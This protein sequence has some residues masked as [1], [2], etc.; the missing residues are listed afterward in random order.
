MSLALSET[1][2]ICFFALRRILCSYL[3]IKRQILLH[4]LD[5]TQIKGPGPKMIKVRK[6]LKL[7]LYYC[8]SFSIL[9]NIPVG[10]LLNIRMLDN[11]S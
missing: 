6:S 8:L 4:A 11:Y 9:L 3:V 7:V 1:Q 2:K 10:L 5:N